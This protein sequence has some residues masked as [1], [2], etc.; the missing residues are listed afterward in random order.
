MGSKGV[1]HRPSPGAAAPAG[2]TRPHQDSLLSRRL[3]RQAQPRPRPAA[4]ADGWDVGTHSGLPLHVSQEMEDLSS[5]K[6]AGLS[7]QACRVDVERVWVW[8]G[9]LRSSERQQEPPPEKGEGVTGC[10]FQ[11]AS[12]RSKSA[13]VDTRPHCL[14]VVR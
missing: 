2:S 9:T 11:V 12:C 7:D 10:R 3:R 13:K 14:G 5:R 8:G 1:S 4:E 6:V